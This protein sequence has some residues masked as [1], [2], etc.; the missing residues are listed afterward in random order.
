MSD[1]SFMKSGFDMLQPDDDE[2]QKNAATVIVAY[3]ENALRTAGLYVTHH[4]KR[5]G[6]TPEDIKRAMMLEMFLFSNRPNMVEKAQ[7]I[8]Q[9]LF[10][11]NSDSDDEDEDYPSIQDENKFTENDCTCPVCHCIN[12]IYARWENWTPNSLFET[13]IKKH[14]D[15]MNTGV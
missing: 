5:N 10:G 13:T 7:E 2:F 3:A 14:I 1:Y 4:K 12:N 9:M 15:T 6:V 8:R 11:N